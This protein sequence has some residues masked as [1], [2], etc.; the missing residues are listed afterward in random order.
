MIKKYIIILLGCASIY[1]M[2]KKYTKEYLEKE[3]APAVESNIKDL[4]KALTIMDYYGGETLVYSGAKMRG[5]TELEIQAIKCFKVVSKDS[6]LDNLATHVKKMSDTEML[7]ILKEVDN[8]TSIDDLI[9]FQ[10]GINEKDKK[11]KIKDLNE[12]EAFNRLIQSSHFNK[13]KK[14]NYSN[15]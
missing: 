3:L 5:A 13:T 10:Y 12:E 14:R 4:K 2:D 6:I 11:I 8:F 1:G 9:T 15:G 7:R